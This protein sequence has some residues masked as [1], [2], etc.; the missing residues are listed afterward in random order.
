MAVGESGY[1]TTIVAI[2][3]VAIAARDRRKSSEA[4]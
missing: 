2:A 1:L 4:R 3:F